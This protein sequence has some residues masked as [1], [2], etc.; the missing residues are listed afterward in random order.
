MT[1]PENWEGRHLANFINKFWFQWRKQTF[2]TDRLS[3]G[4]IWFWATL[5]RPTVATCPRK[6]T[7]WPTTRNP[8]KPIKIHNFFGFLSFFSFG[9]AN[10]FF[11]RA[12]NEYG[13]WTI[14][15][16][17]IT[18]FPAQ[19]TLRLSENSKWVCLHKQNPKTDLSS[20]LSNVH[21]LPQFGNDGHSICWSD[22]GLLLNI[23]SAVISSTR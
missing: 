22:D 9:G 12:C 4:K 16:A 8:T 11:A 17:K 21:L 3:L 6:S 7:S 13:L 2:P 20:Y 18:N 15:N 14:T 5:R 1:F 23:E 19:V 10:C